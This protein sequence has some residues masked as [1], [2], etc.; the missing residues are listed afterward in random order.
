MWIPK[1]IK[2]SIKQEKLESISK[3]DS[4]FL[5]SPHTEKDD[6]EQKEANVLITL[7]VERL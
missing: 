3:M 2:I 1:D 7:F 4:F 6:D 5:N